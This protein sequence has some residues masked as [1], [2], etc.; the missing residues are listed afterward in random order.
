[1][2]DFKYVYSS[3]QKNKATVF[4]T[5]WTFFAIILTDYLQPYLSN[6]SKYVSVAIGAIFAF[7]V[8]RILS[9]HKNTSDLEKIN[10]NYKLQILW[11]LLLALV[12]AIVIILVNKL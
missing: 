1:M 9:K 10:I 11:Y 2:L 3:L 5:L 7:L 8:Y 6:Y 12:Y 4:F